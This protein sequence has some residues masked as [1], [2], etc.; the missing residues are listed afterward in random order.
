[1]LVKDARH[2]SRMQ[3][4]RQPRPVFLPPKVH[5]SG[6]VGI[7]SNT[8]SLN[9]AHPHAMGFFRN[10]WEMLLH[11]PF[12]APL[13]TGFERDGSQLPLSSGPSGGV[14][15]APENASPGFTCSYPNMDGWESC[16]TPDD[17]SC[18]LR[19]ARAS[20]PFFSQYDIHTDCMLCPRTV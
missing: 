6:Q 9:L 7:S 16:N 18:W 15:I 13:D 10:C 17:R 12:F 3:L 20:Q 8:F 4:L 2:V 5:S 11:L 14:V 19:D 1:M